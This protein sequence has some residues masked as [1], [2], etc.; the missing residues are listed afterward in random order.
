MFTFVRSGSWIMWGLDL[1]SC[2]VWV[3]D[4]L[5]SR[6]WTMWWILNGLGIGCCSVYVLERIRLNHVGFSSWA[7][8]DVTPGLYGVWI[9]DNIGSG[10]LFFLVCFFN[11]HVQSVLSI[12]WNWFLNLMGSCFGF[13]LKVG[14]SL[15]QW[16]PSF[17]T[18]YF[19][20]Y[21]LSSVLSI[22]HNVQL[23]FT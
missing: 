12:V 14:H 8:C 6:S 18:T 13:P 3:L 10:I 15:Y 20:D 19:W 22:L 16:T 2:M 17:P 4:F 1:G 11:F 5:R 7:M 23:W 9:L 21:V